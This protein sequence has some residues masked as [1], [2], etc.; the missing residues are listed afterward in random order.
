MIDELFGPGS[1]A[2]I[3]EDIL[4]DIVNESAKSGN[5]EDIEPGSDNWNQATGVAGSLMFAHARIDNGRDACTPNTARGADLVRFKES[6]RLPDVNQSYAS[7]KV[8]ATISGTASIPNGQAGV[9]NGIRY[10]VINGPYDGLTNGADVDVQATTIGSKGNARSGEAFTWINPPQ[11]VSPSAK[12]SKYQAITGG[13]DEET[14]GR[15]K[16]RV[17]N[18]SGTNPGGGNWGQL[19][20][21]AFNTSAAVHAAFV[22]PTILG[23]NTDKTI[24]LKSFDRDLFNFSRQA[25]DGLVGDVR[26]NIHAELSTSITA[27]VDTGADEPADVAILLDIPDS[28]LVGG[29]GGGWLDGSPWPQLNGQTRILVSNVGATGT[30]EVDASTT[31]EPVDL[32]TRVAWWSR[33]TMTFYVRTVISHSGAPGAYQL[34]LD[35]PFVDDLGQTP[36]IGDFISPGAE[37][38]SAYAS[39][40][41]DLMEKLGTGENTN[42]SNLIYHGRA[43]RHPPPAEGIRNG[44]TSGQ[45]TDMKHKNGEIEEIAYSYRSITTPTVPAAL[46][47]PPNVLVPRHFGVY[48]L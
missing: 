9:R 48:P 11:N 32:V 46:E 42:D 5:I 1:M 28:T 38:L 34:V 12:V 14:E 31:V 3:R 24:V 19:R 21:I 17:L 27:V 2:E 43:L 39:T 20:E 16:E 25:P 44:L 7:G 29:T 15:L 37:R 26:G 10:E 6:Y 18:R 40:W 35:A 41:V 30:V 23:P 45:L 8:T 47:L 4:T 33:Y 36:S 22:F 13:Y